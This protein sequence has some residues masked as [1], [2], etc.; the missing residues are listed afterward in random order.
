[1]NTDSRTL[2]IVLRIW[3]AALFMNTL[4]GTAVITDLYTYA[5]LIGPVALLGL[6]YSAVFTLPFV[7]LLLIFLRMFLGMAMAGRQ[8][9]SF[10]FL[11]GLFLTMACFTI[12]FVMVCTSSLPIWSLLMIA[13][14]SGGIAMLLE[15]RPIVE[16][17]KEELGI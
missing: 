11:T 10:F 15:Y 7:S 14:G 17:T 3:A 12:F 13:L 6:F 8:L 2:K 1:M 16:L 5:E 4:M 9:F